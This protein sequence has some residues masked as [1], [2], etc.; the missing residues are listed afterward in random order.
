MKSGTP[1]MPTKDQ[2][3][4]SQL[5]SGEAVGIDP[6]VVTLYAIE[7]LRDKVYQH[8]F[9]IKWVYENLIDQIWLTRPLRLIHV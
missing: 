3:I 9:E 8:G 6:S 1:G 7:D 4:W 5:I 2:W